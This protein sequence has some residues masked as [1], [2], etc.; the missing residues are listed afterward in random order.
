MGILESENQE[1]TLLHLGGLEGSI[2]PGQ[3][4]T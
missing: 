4:A 2:L 1:A 3:V